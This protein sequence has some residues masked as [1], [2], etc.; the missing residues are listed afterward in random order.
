LHAVMNIRTSIKNFSPQIHMVLSSDR[1][2]IIVQ[3]AALGR[4]IL[5]SDQWFP[6]SW[7]LGGNF[8][9]LH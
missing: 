3:H 9:R 1:N 4:S 6:M 8:T 5:M 7:H 2:R